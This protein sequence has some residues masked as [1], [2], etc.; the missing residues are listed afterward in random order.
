MDRLISEL[1]DQ[2][3][4]ASIEPAIPATNEDNIQYQEDLMHLFTMC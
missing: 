3:Q 1:K 4:A 2:W